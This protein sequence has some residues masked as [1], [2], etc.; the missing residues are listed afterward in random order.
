MQKD[1]IHS[2]FMEFFFDW[3]AGWFGGILFSSSKM[4]GQVPLTLV[5]LSN[6]V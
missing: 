3:L 6:Q 2:F 1:K 5:L 4:L